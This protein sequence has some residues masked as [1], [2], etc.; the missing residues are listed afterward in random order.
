MTSSI[1]KRFNKNKGYLR[2]T[3]GLPRTEK[4]ELKL[5]LQ[6]GKVVMVKRGLYRFAE[7]P[8]AG[9]EAEV[10]QVVPDGVFCMHSSWAYYELTTHISA[11]YH[12]AVPKSLKVVIPEFPPIKLYYW[13]EPTFGLGLTHV[14]INGTRVK[15]YDLERSVCDAVKFRNKIGNEILGE[16]LRNYIKRKD[17]N[18]DKLMKYASML[19]ISKTMNQLLQVLL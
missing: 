1:I 10:A 3:G 14:K 13:N 18:L 4:Y 8:S 11:E 17:K 7:T 9:Q 16:I 2:N 6:E 15:I 12:V 19:R 5:L